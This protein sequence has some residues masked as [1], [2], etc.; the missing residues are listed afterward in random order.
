MTRRLESL[1]GPDCEGAPVIDFSD[2]TTAF[3][4]TDQLLVEA[5]RSQKSSL[6]S[7]ATMFKEVD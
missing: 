3:F 2:G 5:G 4:L 1:L 7:H 6:T